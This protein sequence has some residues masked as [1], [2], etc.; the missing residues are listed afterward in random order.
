MKSTPIDGFPTHGTGRTACTLVVPIFNTAFAEGVTTA[1]L[2]EGTR[3]SIT[4]RT[5]HGVWTLLFVL[6]LFSHWE[7][8]DM[9]LRPVL[10]WGLTR[11]VR[12]SRVE[13]PNIGWVT[14]NATCICA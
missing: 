6:K 8:H 1:Q 11:K 3:L 9:F 4:H 12:S 7:G 10:F 5:L 14:N 13:C 2:L